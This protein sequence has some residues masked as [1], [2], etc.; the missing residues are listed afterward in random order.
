MSVRERLGEGD[1]FLDR[2]LLLVF[3]KDV[4]EEIPGLALIARLNF[5]IPNSAGDE[6]ETQIPIA[7]LFLPD[8]VTRFE[9]FF[10]VLPELIG[11]HAEQ[12]RGDGVL[13]KP[14]CYW[15]IV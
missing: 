12:L 5:E 10:G 14:A 13:P 11:R 7:L 9:L 4:T 15:R 3:G 1:R 2:H 8:L 6:P